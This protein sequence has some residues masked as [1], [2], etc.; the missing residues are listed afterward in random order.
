MLPPVSRPPQLTVR[1]LVILVLLLHGGMALFAIRAGVSPATVVPGSGGWD[2][3]WQHLPAA[4]LQHGLP[5][6]LFYLHAQPPL[7]NAYGA[8]WLHCFPL[9]AL[10]AQHTANLLLGALTCAA[11]AV[12][13]RHLTGNILPALA[14]GVLLAFYPP[15]LLYAAYPLYTLE[16][17]ALITFA[18]WA[19]SRWQVSHQVRWLHAFL[20]LL[21]LLML[22]RSFYHPVLLLFALPFAVMLAP[23]S[24]QRP[25]ALVGLL[26]SFPAAAWCLKNLM[27]FG[28]FGMSSWSGMNLWHGVAARYSPQARAA[29]AQQGVIPPLV[30]QVNAFSPPAAFRAAGFAQPV[31]DIPHLARN[32]L[33]NSIYV[34]LGR[35]YGKAAR[36]VIRHDPAHYLRTVLWSY[37]LYCLPAT[38]FRHFTPAQALIPGWF[39]ADALLHGAPL[40]RALA[41]YLG[42]DAGS[43]LVVILPLLLG[44]YAAAAGRQGGWSAARWL[45]LLRAH[46]ALTFCWGIVVYNLLVGC[47][48]ECNDNM[49]FRAEIDPL[50][51]VLL[52]T[53]LWQAAQRLRSTGTRRQP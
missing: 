19:L 49:R 7:H 16:A 10:A 2:F 48:G 42:E 1:L 36:A 15:L 24:A 28:F 32:D 13:L 30:A 46:P 3:F 39:T 38:S 17:T 47:F 4:E 6:A 41:P 20:F 51:L 23:R 34:P 31:S 44:G 12:V 43:L 11:A 37:K 5:H 21:V 45:Q 50:L 9:R 27:L 35:L 33:H 40:T 22:T 25:V 52:L 29:L 26:S 8:L 53:A 14:G 18:A